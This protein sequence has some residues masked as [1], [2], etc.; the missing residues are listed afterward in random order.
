MRGSKPR[1]LPLGDTPMKSSVAC[2]RCYN[3]RMSDEA[4]LPPVIHWYRT[5]LPREVH[6]K[7]HERS[8][9]LGFLQTG[10]Y[11]GV[12]A[13]FG[14]LSMYS[15]SRWP[16]WATVSILFVHGTCYAFLINGFH[17]LVHD[18]VFR[19]RWL[20]RFFLRIISF[21]GWLNHHHFWASHTEHHRFTLHPPDDL[22]V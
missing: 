5:P 8:D 12:L 1:A 17:E 3:A 10:G 13:T 14:G 9:L 22:E 7:L 6:A 11:L 4:R 20:N 18:S 21:L 2:R 15:A 19:T 16:W